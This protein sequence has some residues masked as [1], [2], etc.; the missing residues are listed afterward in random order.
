MA[1]SVAGPPHSIAAAG[2]SFNTGFAA[3]PKTGDNPDL[4][5]SVGD[6]TQ[7]ASIYQRLAALTPSRR[8]QRFVVAL[9]GSK[10]ADLPRQFA[11]AAALHAQLVTVQSGGNDVCAARDP[12]GLTPAADFR[13]SIEAAFA[14]ARARMPDAR[15]FVTS[16]TDEARWNDRSLTI[17]GNESKLADGTLCDP[18]LDP[19]GAP[20]PLRRT[21][22]QSAEQRYNAIL[23]HVCAQNAH[24]RYDGGAFFRLEYEREDIAPANA[25]HPSIAGLRHLAATAWRAGFDYRDTTP[26]HVS[27]S[28]SQTGSTLRIVLAAT[29]AAGVAGIE[30]RFGSRPYSACAGALLLPNRARVTY[31]AVDRNGNSSA[32]Y[33]IIAP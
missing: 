1:P 17:A 26:P 16:L 21:Q 32:A 14:V 22:I 30:C 25:F 29:D 18:D 5:W 9:D 12:S 13:R 28:T 2:D 33:S 31:R 20:S 7:V 4:S 23:R 24:C 11:R 15:I 19:S 8:P 6:D 10:V 27:A 3:R